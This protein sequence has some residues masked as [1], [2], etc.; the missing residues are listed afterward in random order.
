MHF[1]LLISA[2]FASAIIAVGCSSSSDDNTGGTGGDPGTGGV[3]GGTG[4]DPGTGG[5]GGE[6][7]GA[8]ALDGHGRAT[9]VHEQA[10]VPAAATVVAPSAP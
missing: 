10:V 7:V 2:V 6:S 5:T 4:G 9:E 8:T 3:G 1:K